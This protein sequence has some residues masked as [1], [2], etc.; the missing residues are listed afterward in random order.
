MA[1][2]SMRVSMNLQYGA[3]TVADA[4]KRFKDSCDICCMDPSRLRY[5]CGRCGLDQLHKDRVAELMVEE[6]IAKY[7]V[8]RA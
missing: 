4:D 7:G 8:R 2:F 5:E 1:R 6:S 3:R